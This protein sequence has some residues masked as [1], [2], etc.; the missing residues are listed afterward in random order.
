MIV[1]KNTFLTIDKSWPPSH[2]KSPLDSI[3]IDYEKDAEQ[4]SDRTCVLI[5]SA[6]KYCGDL[7]GKK[8]L[9]LG[10]GSGFFSRLFKQWGASSVVALD[11]SPKMI[12]LARQHEMESPLGI[13]YNVADVSNI[14]VLGQF[15]IV[16]AAFLLHYA[17]TVDIL[18]GMCDSIFINLRPGGKF[19]AFNENPSF[20]IHDGIK[21]GVSVWTDGEICDGVPMHRMHYKGDEPLF[22]LNYYHWEKQTYEL[23]LQR[24]GLMDVT[25]ASFIQSTDAGTG[26]PFGYWDNYVSCFSTTVLTCRKPTAFR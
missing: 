23:A 9:D 21:Y 17:P 1:S 4:R 6:Q 25:W 14:G 12:E 11:L 19:V 5:P 26:L 20:P 18:Q 13:E 10:C 2:K 16:F 15:D 22:C 7:T 24:A 3:A 8:V